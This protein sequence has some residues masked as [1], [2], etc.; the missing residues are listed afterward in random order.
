MNCYCSKIG[1]FFALMLFS[2]LGLSAQSFVKWNA[3]Y[4]QND[5][6]TIR[7]WQGGYSVGYMEDMSGQGHFFLKDNNNS[8]QIAVLPR[9][10]A[11]TDFRIKDDSV[12]F[13]GVDTISDRGIVGFFDIN[14]L[15]A[16]LGAINYGVLDPLIFAPPSLKYVTYPRRMDVYV[17][18]GMTHIAFVGDMQTVSGGSIVTA[19]TMG[20]AFWDG[21]NW[22]MCFYDNN[23]GVFEF[24]DVA[25]SGSYVVAA[26]R[27]IVQPAKVVQVFN[28]SHYLL[29]APLN[30]GN[31]F[32][33]TGNAPLGD[34]LVEDISS[35]DFMLAYHSNDVLGLLNT[36]LQHFKVVPATYSLSVQY[37][38]QT[39]HGVATPVYSLLAM[40]QMCFDASVSRV[41]LMQDAATAT[42]PSVESC[43]FMYDLATML[44]GGVDVSYVPNVMLEKIDAKASGGYY[45]IGEEAGM[46]TIVEEVTPPPPVSQCHIVY[47]LVDG[48]VAPETSVD[49]SCGMDVVAFTKT[50]S[51]LV[52][53]VVNKYD[54]LYVNC[55][56]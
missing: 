35:T 25:A 27:R 43:V 5:N 12:F 6:S 31:F 51:W 28:L 11:V 4:W 10:Y 54:E 26:A 20:S 3:M 56:E 39:C 22:R 9:G 2:G 33:L 52:P 8:M 15:Y 14:M 40:K 36:E 19:T 1:V 48:R 44:L 49:V 47:T 42:V 23:T 46:L 32:Q 34:I 13:C 17:L 37:T 24:T 41:L 30:P 16:G 29:G 38:I 55:R 50:S 7:E 45:G 21:M 53:D 18:D